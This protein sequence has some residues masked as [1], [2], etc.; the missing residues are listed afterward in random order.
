MTA[1]RRLARRRLGRG[2]LVL[3]L[4]EVAHGLVGVTYA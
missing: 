3:I 2:G 1:R 4:F